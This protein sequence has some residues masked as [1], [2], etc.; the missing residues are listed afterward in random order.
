VGENV[1]QKVAQ[2]FYRQNQYTFS[3]REN[4]RPNTLAT[5]VIFIKLPKVNNHTIGENSP[6][7]VNG[8]ADVGLIL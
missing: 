1:A 6:N 3:Q 7:L 8:Q 2:T 5:S 4:S